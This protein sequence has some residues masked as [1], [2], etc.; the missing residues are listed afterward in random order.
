M[1]I[2]GGGSAGWLAA[3]TLD[4]AL[5]RDGRRAAAI[6]VVESPTTPRI[7]VGEAT[8]P[9]LRRTLRR[10]G[11][12]EAEF[13]S[14]ADATFKQA[15]VF[16]DWSAPGSAFVHPFHTL[17]GD[18]AEQAGARYLRS[19]RAVPFADLVTPQPALAA[20]GRAP[21]A[22]ETADYAGELPYAY[23]MDAEAFAEALAARAVARGVARRAAHVVAPERA[24]GQPLREVRTAEGERLRADLF[25]DAT[26]FRR[27]LIGDHG[28]RD[29]S[30]H[31]ICDAAV[32]LRAPPR[33]GPTPP[34]TVARASA[35]GWTWDIPLRTRRGRGYVHASAHLSAD[36]AEAELRRSEPQAG[37]EARR[38]A[39]EVGRLDAPWDADVA[40]VG[41][42]AGFV[43]PLES[44]GL[45]LADLAAGLLAENAPLAGHNPALARAYNDHMTAAHDE[46]VDFVNLHYAASPRR[47]TPFWRDAADPARRTDRVAHLLEL[48]ES[49]PPVASDFSSSLQVFNH[50]NWEFI[51]HGLGWR[52]GAMASAG[53]GVRLE[54]SSAVMAELRRLARRLPP[55]DALLDDLAR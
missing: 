43:E 44:T 12:A 16:A 26:G 10:L 20:A 41:L 18:E 31:L 21:R 4:A 15:I 53:Q 34:L 7:G 51:L 5:N 42:A 50:R 11:L 13:L 24:P 38:I 45:H 25:V 8:I 48:W 47:D 28:F 39:F 36:D 55:H 6:T 23:H 52:P 2:V 1:L 29:Q 27:L 3:A 9:T 17:P 35:G 54:P 40:A 30:R 22:A 32:A 33:A 46:I 37:G 19:D 49:R 14:A